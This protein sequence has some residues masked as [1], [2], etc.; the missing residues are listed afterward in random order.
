MKKASRTVIQKAVALVFLFLISG[1]VTLQ[2]VTAYFDQE[3]YYTH[4]V[5]WPGETLSIISKWYTGRGENWRLLA[6]TNPK[7][8]PDRIRIG[9][10][11]RIPESIME[12]SEPLPQEFL[13]SR[14]PLPQQ[15][16]TPVKTQ[17]DEEL[18][19]LFGPKP[20]PSQ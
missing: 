3:S 8:D 12:R 15:Q 20:F 17:S 19:Q 1:C 18:P 9:E 13:P 5:R 14:S 11:I 4:T 2:K 7:L 16:A 10:N 6:R